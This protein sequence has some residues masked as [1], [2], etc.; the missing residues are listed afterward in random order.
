MR[1]LD[2]KPGRGAALTSRRGRNA[3]SALSRALLKVPSI[4]LTGELSTVLL[5]G[6]SLR[7]RLGL[8]G[9][10]GV[11][12]EAGLHFVGIGEAPVPNVERRGP[13]NNE[14]LPSHGVRFVGRESIGIQSAGLPDQGSG[15]GVALLAVTS[16]LK[17]ASAPQARANATLCASSA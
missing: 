2:V 1:Q 13:P 12:Q 5:V 4:A 8:I 14:I 11:A 3:V 17:I 16:T 10:G 6:V 15:H 7:N 9:G